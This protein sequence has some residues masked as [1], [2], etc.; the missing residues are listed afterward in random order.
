MSQT[1][2]TTLVCEIILLK[3]GMNDVLDLEDDILL[4]SVMYVL[5]VHTS[6]PSSPKTLRNRVFSL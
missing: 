1:L 6:T 2:A 3:I 4:K 5:H